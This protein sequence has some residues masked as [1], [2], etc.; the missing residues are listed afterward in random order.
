MSDQADHPSDETLADKARAGDRAAFEALCDRYLTVVYNRLR[1][2]LPP[3]AVEDVTQEVFISAMRGIKHYS[4]RSSFRTWL[5]AVARH[6]V[7][8]YY[9][10]NS[11]RPETTPLDA[12]E[13]DPAAHDR[14]EERAIVRIALQHLPA[15]YQDILLLRFA[16]GLPFEEIAC[17]LE[18]T[19][20]A[21]KSR[22]RRAVAA[23]AEEME[24]RGE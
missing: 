20:E 21:A 1:A 13:H 18:I 9:R 3:E 4:G 14:W 22:Y 11:R 15:H 19:L 24:P 17:S 12:Q 8:D 5:A 6:K 23:I 7:A 16:E 10:Q 2:L